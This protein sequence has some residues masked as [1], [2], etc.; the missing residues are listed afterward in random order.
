L[1]PRDRQVA[2]LPPRATGGPP[3][4]RVGGDC[5]NIQ[6]GDRVLLIVENDPKFASVLVDM[7]HEK[8]FKA[9]VTSSGEVALEAARA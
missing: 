4:A 3:V 2:N 7:A 6:P 5:D 1:P 9:L 8:G